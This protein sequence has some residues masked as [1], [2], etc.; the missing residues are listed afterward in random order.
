VESWECAELRLNEEGRMKNEGKP[1]VA[2]EELVLVSSFFI[3]P[4]SFLG[5]LCLNH[6]AQDVHEQL[7][8]L[9]N[10]RG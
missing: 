9:L 2:H 8:T 4:S 1:A 10:P 6:F 5:Q 7:L 3:F